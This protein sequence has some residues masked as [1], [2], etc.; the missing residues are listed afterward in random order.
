MAI[1][2][3]RVNGDAALD[4]NRTREQIR[5]EVRRILE[6][7]ERIDAEEDAEYGPER[8]G[9]ELPE[10]FRSRQERRRK[11][12]EAQARLDAEEVELKAE[13]AEKIRRRE[14]EERETG[15]KK[16]GTTLDYY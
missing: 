14:E 2:G 7:A 3:R 12:K 13:Q 15:R 6:E 8:R 10:G 1:D 9:D 5:T 16:R 11:L 4:R